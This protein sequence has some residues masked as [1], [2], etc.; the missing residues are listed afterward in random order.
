MCSIAINLG[1]AVL[2]PMIGLTIFAPLQI[3]LSVGRPEPFLFTAAVYVLLTFV[4][5]VSIDSLFSRA[6]GNFVWRHPPP[7]H[8]TSPHHLQWATQGWVGRLGLEDGSELD[9]GRGMAHVIGPRFSV[10]SG[11]QPVRYFRSAVA[12]S[13]S[14]FWC[15]GRQRQTRL[16]R[17]RKGCVAK[18]IS[19]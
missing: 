2:M 5:D 3:D 11:R 1:I 9:D 15:D 6:Y 17:L 7:P 14:A 19:E 10:S 13:Q 18:A 8:P 4:L 12:D 16:H